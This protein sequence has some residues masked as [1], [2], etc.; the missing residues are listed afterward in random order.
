[1]VA[2]LA[3]VGVPDGPRADLADVGAHDGATLH[4]TAGSGLQRWCPCWC[5]V[6]CAL[7]YTAS[8]VHYVLLTC[9]VHC[10]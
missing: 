9:C 7:W 4:D 8:Y 1:M 3:D 2:D 10:Y 6:W 5:C